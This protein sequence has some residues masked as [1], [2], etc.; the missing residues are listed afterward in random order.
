ME[1]IALQIIELQKVISSLQLKNE[2][3]AKQNEAQNNTQQKLIRQLTDTAEKM[4]KEILQMKNEEQ[5]EVLKKMSKFVKKQD[6]DSYNFNSIKY[7]FAFINT[8]GVCR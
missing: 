8:N 5:V 4:Q 2:Q 1:N 3:T 6:N 7:R